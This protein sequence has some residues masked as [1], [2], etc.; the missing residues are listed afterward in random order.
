MNIYC[1]QYDISW[2]DKESN[3]RTVRRII[4]AADIEKGSLVLFPEMFSSGFS[5]EVKSICEG[6]SRLAE[7][8]MRDISTQTGVYTI[9]GVVTSSSA[10]RGRNEAL[11]FGPDGTE[12]ARYAKIHPFSFAK[13][14]EHYDSGDKIVLF[15]WQGC[16]VSPF[17]CYDLRCPEIF[18]RAVFRG[19][20][21]FVIIANWPAVREEHWVA[22]LKAR[23]IENQC[24]VA[25]VNRTGKTWKNKYSGRSMIIDPRGKVLADAED[26]EGI[27]SAAIDLDDMISYRKKFPV[28]K[29]AYCSGEWI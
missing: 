9:G 3:F 22:L 19:A 26:K 1:L 6:E 14:D 21:L 27:I 10:G 16:V 5:M 4:D 25:G 8:F 12:I 2:E 7:E 11:A 15:D 29:D 24:Y 28:L 20:M 18:R 17:I 23:A 13:E